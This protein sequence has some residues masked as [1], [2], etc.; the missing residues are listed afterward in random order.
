MPVE[1]GAEFL[2]REGF[3]AVR[4]PLAVDAL[5]STEPD[6]G[7]MPSSLSLMIDD[8]VAEANGSSPRSAIQCPPSRA[9]FSAHCPPR[10]FMGTHAILR[11]VPTDDV[12]LLMHALY[13]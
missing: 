2:K 13:M 7:C 1:A 11:P 3:N 12:A 4:I 8:D 10:P 9:P 5:V 6:G